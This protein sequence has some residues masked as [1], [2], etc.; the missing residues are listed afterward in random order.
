M[1]TTPRVARNG[2]FEIGESGP[3][4]KTNTPA[5]SAGVFFLPV[6]FAAYGLPA[7]DFTPRRDLS[8]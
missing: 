7:V 2:G 1:L 5:L 6:S 3:N 8:F 4:E